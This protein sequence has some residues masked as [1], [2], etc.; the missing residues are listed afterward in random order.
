M[1][2]LVLGINHQIQWVR[3]WSLS[4]TGELERFERSQKDQFRELV[5]RRIAERG[6]QFIGE[7]AKHG[8]GAIV[9][10]IC[11]SDG[12]RYANIEMHPDERATRRIPNNYEAN[13]N[14]SA[15]QKEAF[16][17]ER[18]EYMFGRAVAEAANAES[19]IV[20][21]GRYHTPGL[22]RRFRAAGHQVDEA[23]IQSE[24]WYI[25]DWMIHM[26]RL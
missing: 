26:L 18:E 14:M 21:C 19:I 6:V 23:D 8:E 13:P 3:I 17:Q 11:D 4:S 15:E 16:H 1:R 22:A 5:R 7:E 25:E 9:K 20:I 24:S 2:V 10:E 12:C